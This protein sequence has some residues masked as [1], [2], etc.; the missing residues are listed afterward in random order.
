MLITKFSESKKIRLSGLE[1][2]S[3]RFWQFKNMIME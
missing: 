1:N 2:Q 3:I